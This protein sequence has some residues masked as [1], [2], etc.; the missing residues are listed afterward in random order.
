MGIFE[1]YKNLF[2]SGIVN[3]KTNATFLTMPNTMIYLKYLLFFISSNSFFIFLKFKFK[4]YSLNFP[5]R[6]SP[7]WNGGILE[8]SYGFGENF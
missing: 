6:I 7:L 5:C 1:K 4:S 8:Y 3:K 2:H